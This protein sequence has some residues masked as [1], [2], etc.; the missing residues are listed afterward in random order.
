M[1]LI[2][3]SVFAGLVYFVYPR[4]DPDRLWREA[5]AAIEF[6]RIDQAESKLRSILRSRTPTP[7]DRMLAARIALANGKNDEAIESLREIPDQSS[8]AP[9]AWHMIGRIELERHRARYA[10]IADRKALELNPQLIPAH[11]ALI[12][13]YGM[14]LR[15]RELNAEFKI[16]SELTALNYHDMFTRCLWQF[17]RW[18]ADNAEPLEN[19]IKADPADRYSRLALAE[20]LV[21]QPGTDSR[22]EEI[23]A[24][25]GTDDLNAKAILVERALNK[26]DVDRAITMLQS[27][28]GQNPRL[29]RLRGQAALM[30]G[31]AA[32]AVAHFKDALQ[33]EPYDRAALAEL[34]KALTITG[35]KAAAESVIN[36]VRKFDDVYNLINRV[37]QMN[38]ETAESELG[39]LGQACD[40]AGLTDE[41]IGWYNLAIARN[42]LDAESQRAL[43]R[44]RIRARD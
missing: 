42:P 13:I 18:G 31:D 29:A 11:K 38:R 37:S 26:G 44:I 39:A 3:V 40:A 34:A 6:G 4:T 1:G 25:V 5:D 32:G 22:I 12:Y 36:R 35:D 20:M 27:A 8:L 24:P 41:A 30:K 17:N 28:H 19:F 14:Q 10:E 16:L 33:N 21:A 23:L 15:R 7:D 2:A 43:Q 9:A